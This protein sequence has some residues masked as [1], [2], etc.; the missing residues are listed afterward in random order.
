MIYRK[1]NLQSHSLLFIKEGMAAAMW[2]EV[3]DS[4]NGKRTD[5]PE[6]LELSVVLLL[7]GDVLEYISLFSYTSE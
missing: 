1:P 6:L 4:E 5:S 7:N 3:V 2:R